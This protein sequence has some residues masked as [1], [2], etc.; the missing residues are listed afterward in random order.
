M[1]TA[2]S[3]HTRWTTWF[4]APNKAPVFLIVNQLA[5]PNPVDIFYANDWVAQAFPLYSGTPL[6][7]LMEQ[8][9]WLIQ[10]KAA[11]LSSLG[12]L[13]DRR[14]LSD[15]SWGWAYRSEAAWQAQLLHWQRHQF[16]T[17]HD[18]QV[19]FRLM[20]T[21]IVRV[22]M[23]AMQ[24]T[25]WT[26]LLNPVTE[27]MLDMPA[28]TVFSR[29]ADCPMSQIERPFVL[30]PHLIAAWEQSD[31]ALES[32]AQTLAYELWEAQGEL[33]M[34]LDT[35]SGTLPQRLASWLKHRRLQGSRLQALTFHDFLAESGMPTPRLNPKGLH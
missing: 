27:L 5:A 29:P 7:H 24:P 3:H 6:A 21:R 31:L 1:T 4:S 8:G 10:P 23:P 17:L 15:E 25:D 12:R 9:P 18:E 14:A 19:V 2:V 30:E 16:A 11:S 26:S 13:L 28:P 33:A 35:P 22:L 32:Y 20:D 34:K